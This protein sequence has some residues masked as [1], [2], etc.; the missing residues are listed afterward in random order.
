MPSEPGF[1]DEPFP[2]GDDEGRAAAEARYAS[3]PP[4]HPFVHEPAP[5]PPKVQRPDGGSIARGT[6]LAGL[7][8]ATMVGAVVSVQ[9]LGWLAAPIA[10]ILGPSAVLAAWAAALHLT[11]GEKFDDHPWV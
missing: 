7:A 3:T 6:G 8:A 5:P 2:A 4:L 10:A 1:A 9:R 11:G